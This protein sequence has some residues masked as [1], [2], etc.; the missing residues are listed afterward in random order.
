V[1]VYDP[2]LAN[3]EGYDDYILLAS[4]DAEQPWAA[5]PAGDTGPTRLM[6]ASV[7]RHVGVGMRV[8]QWPCANDRA[9]PLLI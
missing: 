5:P 6:Y 2:L 9:S 4:L 1:F 8:C 7:F 3:D